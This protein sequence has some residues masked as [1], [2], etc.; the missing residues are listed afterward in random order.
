MNTADHQRYLA[1]KYFEGELADFYDKDN[2]LF[3]D[4]VEQEELLR[5][6]DP[7]KVKVGTHNLSAK[8][9][10]IQKSPI[11]YIEDID[12][13]LA[14][15]DFIRSTKD[16][17]TQRL[18]DAGEEMAVDEQ[19]EEE[20]DETSQMTLE[21]VNEF[22]QKLKEAKKAWKLPD[23]Y[24]EEK[25]PRRKIFKRISEED[26]EAP[27][28]EEEELEE[29]QAN[30]LDVAEVEDGPVVSLEDPRIENS[31]FQGEIF[32]LR[33]QAR[34]NERM[35]KDLS[36][37]Q[38][39]ENEI[40]NMEKEFERMETESTAPHPIIDELSQPISESTAKN[41]SVFERIQMSGLTETEK[42]ASLM[43]S[44]E[45]KS[46]QLY[47]QLQEPIYYKHYVA[48]SYRK[49]YEDNP[50]DNMHFLDDDKN[51]NLGIFYDVNINSQKLG[52]DSENPIENFR[53]YRSKLSVVSSNGKKNG[54]MENKNIGV[55]T[56]PNFVTGKNTIIDMNLHKLRP[57]ELEEL[58]KPKLNFFGQGRRKESKAIAV[59]TTP[60]TGK[61]K[62]NNRELIE[63]FIEETCCYHVVLPIRAANKLCEIDVQLY[64][65]GGG[66]TGQSQ[67]ASLAVSK[68]LVRAYPEL[69][70]VLHEG[71]FFYSDNRQ[72]EA[73]K[74]GR[75]K[76]RKSWTYVR[77]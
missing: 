41:L 53:G 66:I 3:Y 9:A 59:I 33:K 55:S 35:F 61:I 20:T 64:L 34:D 76:A 60:G 75:Y 72:V 7:V 19:E 50:Y 68:A 5:I 77:R 13:A 69:Y 30:E 48:H 56:N 54:M 43:N 45:N 22:Y 31:V 40:E 25:K 21:S 39:V 37:T 24:Q 10:I 74:T 4:R 49:G 28:F 32:E 67:A 2:Q 6:V 71:Y 63:Y 44:N 11:G 46:V 42:Y 52:N 16:E 58:Q 73:K 51:P 62:V 15:Q 1:L 14:E 65:T 70:Q 18:I 47:R 12:E 17:R 29:N 26:E 27:E 57:Q 8:G 38:F 23:E 36:Y